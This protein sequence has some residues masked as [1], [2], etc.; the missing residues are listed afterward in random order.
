[1][2]MLHEV[3][4]GAGLT[5]WAEA[6]LLVFFAAFLAVLGWVYGVRRA[7]DFEP[8]ASLPLEENDVRAPERRVGSKERA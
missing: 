3:M 8:M 2:G 5:F 1:M 4:A 6:A 7:E